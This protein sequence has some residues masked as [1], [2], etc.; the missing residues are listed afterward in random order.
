MNK[1][2]LAMLP[3]LFPAF[4][5]KAMAQDEGQGKDG[6]KEMDE[7]RQQLPGAYETLLQYYKRIEDGERD[8]Y[9]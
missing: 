1:I 5:Y 7:I 9:F 2:M 6:K 8:L 3:L 4:T